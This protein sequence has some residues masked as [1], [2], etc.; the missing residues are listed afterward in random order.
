MITIGATTV[1][2]PSITHLDR[3]V[4]YRLRLFCEADHQNDAEYE[5]TRAIAS[6]AFVLRELR[7]EKVEDGENSVVQAVLESSTDDSRM[8]D[9]IAE[10]LR[11]FPGTHSTEWTKTEAE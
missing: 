5:V 9:A 8:M 4:F 7:T 1:K 6:Q 3:R 2:P 10:S 11:A